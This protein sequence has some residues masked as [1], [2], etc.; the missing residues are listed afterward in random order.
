MNDC[1]NVEMREALPDLAHGALHDDRRV[2][3]ERHIDGCADCADEIAII[4][5]VLATAAVPA[6]DTRRIS[7]AIPAYRRK[8]RFPV[9]YLQLAAAALVG[10]VGISTALVYHDRGAGSGPRSASAVAAVQAPVTPDRGVALVATADLS[11][12][13]LEQLIQ[14]MTSLDAAPPADP[15]PYVLTS[16]DWG[17]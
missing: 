12:D 7:A 8:R 17:S 6:V 3:V 14:S 16:F 1:Q 5:A 13:H 4:R 10:A 11:D 2:I 9:S 15:E